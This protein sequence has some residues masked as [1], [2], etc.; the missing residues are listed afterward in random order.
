LG[1]GD[2]Q[3]RLEPTEIKISCPIQSLSA[4]FNSFL[5]CKNGTTYVFGYYYLTLGY[6]AVNNNL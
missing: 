2:V 5:V 3:P 1:Q 6:N 4:K